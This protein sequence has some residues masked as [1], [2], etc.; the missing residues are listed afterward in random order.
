MK[1]ID[2][3]DLDRELIVKFLVKLGLGWLFGK[4]YSTKQLTKLIEIEKKLSHISITTSKFQTSNQASEFIHA[5]VVISQNYFNSVLAQTKGIFGLE[6]LHDLNIT[7]L[8][9]KE[10][11]VRLKQKALLLNSEEILGFRITNTSLKEQGGI[12]EVIAYGTAIFNKS[13]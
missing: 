9:R 3:I 2:I 6:S 7:E 8:A 12:V 10:A 11:I 1:L 13:Q 4:K 5:S